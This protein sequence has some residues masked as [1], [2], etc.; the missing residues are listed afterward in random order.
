MFTD[1]NSIFILI[2]CYFIGSIPF[3]LL[4]SKITK[5]NDPRLFGSKNIG[6]TNMLRIGAWKIGLIENSE[7]LPKS[8]TRIFSTQKQLMRLHCKTIP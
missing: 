3:G 8:K 4:I 7:W 2:I 5:K 6:A 1:Y